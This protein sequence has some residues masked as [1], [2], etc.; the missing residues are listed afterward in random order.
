MF[1][2][3]LINAKVLRKDTVV[4]IYSGTPLKQRSCL[5]HGRLCSFI[6]KRARIWTTY[7]IPREESEVEYFSRKLCSG[8]PQKK[9]GVSNNKLMVLEKGWGGK[10]RH[11]TG[12]DTKFTTDVYRLTEFA[13][14]DNRTFQV[15]HQRCTQVHRGN[16]NTRW[17]WQFPAS[18]RGE[19]PR[20][21]FQ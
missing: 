21:V 6:R 19:Y 20:L 9:A 2:E 17:F 12:V 5:I 10:F 14:T 3:K 15:N 7:V 18:G 4:G 8:P 11:M 1:Q 13:V 16:V